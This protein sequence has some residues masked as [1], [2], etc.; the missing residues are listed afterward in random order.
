METSIYIRVVVDMF[1]LLWE[2]VDIWHTQCIVVADFPRDFANI[3]L[4]ILYDRCQRWEFIKENKNS[5][6]KALKKKR[7]QELDQESA[8]EKKENKNSTKK[9]KLRHLDT[10]EPS[11]LEKKKKTFFFS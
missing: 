10:P 11:D 3:L 1:F 4:L 5:T 2:Q 8:Q 7:K 6:K 9:A